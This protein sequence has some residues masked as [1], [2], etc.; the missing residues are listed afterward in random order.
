MHQVT[1][2]RLTSSPQDEIHLLVITLGLKSGKRANVLSS[3][4]NKNAETIPG[5]LY[6]AQLTVSLV[7]YAV[8]RPRLIFKSRCL[9]P[10]AVVGANRLNDFV[11]KPFWTSRTVVGAQDFRSHKR[12]Q[13][14]PQQ[15][16]EK[17]HCRTSALRSRTDGVFLIRHA[18][19]RSSTHR[20]KCLVMVLVASVWQ[21]VCNKI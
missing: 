6:F 16:A 8:A 20:K 1:F 3:A 17:L 21:A 14:C 4:M 9:R 15:A 19:L 13:Q 5:T 2:S 18:V 10:R 11:C 7:E 12:H